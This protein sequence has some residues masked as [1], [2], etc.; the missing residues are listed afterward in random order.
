MST[1]GWN[2]VNEI[3]ATWEPKQ[4]GSTKTQNLVHLEPTPQSYLI[5]WYVETKEAV[6]GNN[7]KIH[8]LKFH[9]AGNKEHVIGDLTNGYISVWGTGVL[10]DLIAKNIQPGQFIKIDWNGVQQPKKAGGKPYHGWTVSTNNSVAP[11]Q[12]DSPAMAQPATNPP[13]SG[14]SAAQPLGGF[15]G[16]G[17]QPAAN[18]SAGS[19]SDAVMDDD[20]DDLP[21]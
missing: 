21:F 12:V 10:D 8:K 14:Q 7:S 20:D 13:A 18:T 4:T 6:G 16:G 2:P 15:P 19:V 1:E 17:V 11:I 5:G 3:T 9:E